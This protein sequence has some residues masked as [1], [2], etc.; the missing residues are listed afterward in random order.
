MIQRSGRSGPGRYG[1]K[2]V[3]I[4]SAAV[5]CTYSC[6]LYTLFTALPVPLPPPRAR[7]AGAPSRSQLTS[8]LMADTTRTFDIDIK[9]QSRVTISFQLHTV[10]YGLD[11]TSVRYPSK[12]RTEI[13]STYQ[14]H[15]CH[16]GSRAAQRSLQKA[17]CTDAHARVH[18]YYITPQSG[19]IGERCRSHVTGRH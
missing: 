15:R 5:P 7:A 8:R 13:L 9:T 10:A 3:V 1:G 18:V 2:L 11:C 14:R 19:G 4:H 16:P 12:Y 6:S 17:Q